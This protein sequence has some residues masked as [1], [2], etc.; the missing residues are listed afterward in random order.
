MNALEA[1]ITCAIRE[2][3]SAMREHVFH[4]W[5]MNMDYLKGNLKQHL[6]EIKFKR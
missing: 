4:N 3:S 5:T 6:N 2:I 1:S